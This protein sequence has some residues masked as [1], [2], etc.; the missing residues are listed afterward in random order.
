MINEHPWHMEMESIKLNATVH[1]CI[2][3]TDASTVPS[4]HELIH[5]PPDPVSVAPGCDG[6]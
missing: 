5:Y 1:L 6:A 3:S 4:K 2:V